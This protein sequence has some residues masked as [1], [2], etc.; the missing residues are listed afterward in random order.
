MNKKLNLSFTN[1]NSY[2]IFTIYFTN[3]PIMYHVINICIL[4][5]GTEALM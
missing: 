5:N 2:N 3:V 1:A 4:K